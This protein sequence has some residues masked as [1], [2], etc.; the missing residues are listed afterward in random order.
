MTVVTLAGCDLLTGA[1]LGRLSRLQ[2][3]RLNSCPQVT[4]AS[5]QASLPGEPGDSVFPC[6]ERNG[7]CQRLWRQ[8]V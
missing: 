1:G 6:R 7:C 8:D 5:I 3:L 2:T 4:E